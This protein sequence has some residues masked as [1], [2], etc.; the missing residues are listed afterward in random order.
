MFLGAVLVGAVARTVGYPQ[1]VS[2]LAMVRLRVRETTTL[3][4][5]RV[6]FWEWVG[7]AG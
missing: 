1:S 6:G 7:A 2:M 5:F 3:S 4:A